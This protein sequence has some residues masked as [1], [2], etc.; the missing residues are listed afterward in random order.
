MDTEDHEQPHRINLRHSSLMARNL[1]FVFFTGSN[2]ENDRSVEGSFTLMGRQWPTSGR[3][4]QF[5][6][7]T[8]GVWPNSYEEFKGYKL[9]ADFTTGDEKIEYNVIHDYSDNPPENNFTT[10]DFRGNLLG[11]W[12]ETSIE[13]SITTYSQIDVENEWP[14][15]NVWG[16]YMFHE[17]HTKEN[18]IFF[19]NGY[20]PSFTPWEDNIAFVTPGNNTETQIYH[21]E[22][23][24]SKRFRIDEGPFPDS[25][26]YA[27]EN[28][29]SPNAK[30][31]L[32]S[33]YHQVS[34]I[35][36]FKPE[37]Q[38]IVDFQDAV[39]FTPPS[40]TLGQPM[41]DLRRQIAYIDLGRG[42]N[43]VGQGY[44]GF[45]PLTNKNFMRGMGSLGS[46]NNFYGFGRMIDLDLM[47]ESGDFEVYYETNL[48]E[49][50]G[51]LQTAMNNEYILAS[52]FINNGTEVLNNMALWFNSLYGYA[53]GSGRL[54]YPKI[55]WYVHPRIKQIVGKDVVV[56][57]VPFG[58]GA[59]ISET[60]YRLEIYHSSQKGS[61]SGGKYSVSGHP[62]NVIE[63]VDEGPS[64]QSPQFTL[65]GLNHKITV[66]Y[67]AALV[68]WDFD[69]G[70]YY[71][72][73][74]EK[75]EEL[76]RYS[77]KNFIKITT[78]NVSGPSVLV[79]ESFDEDALTYSRKVDGEVV[80]EIVY[81]SRNN[82]YQTRSSPTDPIFTPTLVMNPDDN[83]GRT[84]TYSMQPFSY[85]TSTTGPHAF[86]QT[87][88]S[89]GRV[90][91][92]NETL[93]GDNVQTTV[94]TNG[95]VV[96]TVMTRDGTTVGKSWVVYEE[97]MR[98]VTE[99]VATSSSATSHADAGNLTTVTTFYG[100]NEGDLPWAVKSIQ[101]PDGR[102]SN[103]TYQHNSGTGELT[104]TVTT[105]PVEET[106]VVNRRGHLVSSV[107]KEN[108]VTLSSATANTH[109][110][111]GR[112]TKITYLDNTF[113]TFTYYDDARG[114]LSAYTDRNGVES[115][116]IYD[117]LGRLRSVE[118]DID[119]NVEYD[120]F[121][122]T[123]THTGGYSVSST[124]NAFGEILSSSSTF[125][126]GT[127]TTA[128]G[129][130][131][132]T[133]NQQTTGTVVEAR[134]PDGSL[135][136]L[137][138]T[139]V[140]AFT[141]EYGVISSP[142]PAHGGN[143]S[144]VKRGIDASGGDMYET[145]F[146]DAAGRLALIEQPSASGNGVARTVYHYNDKGQQAKV[147]DADGHETV[148][149]YHPVT[150]RRETV[151]RGG[152]TLSSAVSFTGGNQV[153]TTSLGG[154]EIRKVV[155]NPATHSRTI[156]PWGNSALNTSVTPDIAG[157]A[158]TISGPGGSVVQSYSN[159]W[160]LVGS[161][162][163]D[164]DDHPVADATLLRDAYNRLTNINGSLGGAP[165][166]ATLSADGRIQNTVKNGHTTNFNYT[167]NHQT[168]TANT[169][170][171][172]VVVETNLKGELT[173]FSRPGAPSLAFNTEIDNNGV[174]LE[175]ETLDNGAKT[176][177]NANNAGA[178]ESKDYAAG[179][180]HTAS[181]T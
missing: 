63:V 36:L 119:M 3:I 129:F 143:L 41:A 113:E 102:V 168:L 65:T 29:F 37:F 81:P 145:T 74:L 176:T 108:G 107:S 20:S 106:T 87:F 10:G 173:G 83:G 157:R 141:I 171:G 59:G 4:N 58:E 172:T 95:N 121:T 122:T 103:F 138:G 160:A 91:Q 49:F 97:G 80:S 153:V 131:Y 114:L 21:Y 180:G 44:V 64:L 85:V 17:A 66:E 89:Y 170:A 125:E 31:F 76:T 169:Q 110:S 115:T 23:T 120:G 142:V 99:A 147:V 111:W 71:W 124:T 39:F 93:Q 75:Q 100:G 53:S 150:G 69:H 62:F 179:P 166:S 46:R 25:N 88:D 60:S 77:F 82:F 30:H 5:V 78:E 117:I 72:F 79:E 33:T 96:E 43:G 163:K 154:Q 90:T 136:A 70:R 165:F 151:T 16:Y 38:H 104:T 105:G 27:P 34:G 101:Y 123:A 18:S 148:F 55:E 67:D 52:Q 175:L 32:P 116:Y 24:E 15:P 109:D 112:P 162:T 73:S 48:N 158:V 132:T 14:E 135:T 130:I 181:A 159:D 22:T 61:F 42:I 177:W 144:F 35:L 155:T 6:S 12:R 164:A 11:E 56:N 133:T 98:K 26:I 84:V 19:L 137:S 9:I 94:T 54:L 7:V 68:G 140:E 146:Y 127:V 118:S 45:G 134:Y 2:L 128:D 167:N 47:S 86:S 28:Q 8:T 139:G 156:T 51:T 161:L 13:G 40:E 92:R 178:T 57:V 152:R 174:T 126:P 149:G 1:G 50:P